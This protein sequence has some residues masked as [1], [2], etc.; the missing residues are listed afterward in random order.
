VPPEACDIVPVHHA[1]ALWDNRSLPAVHR[2]FAELLGTEALWVTMDR[3]GFKPPAS[4]S[5][6]YDRESAIHWDARPRERVADARPLLQGMLFLTD[7]S[8]ELGPFECVPSLYRDVRRWIAEH[9]DT[10]EP[11]VTGREIVRVVGDAG[12]LVVWNALLPHRAGRNDGT[13]PRITQYIAMR[14]AG[15][16]E[17][18]EERVALWR[19]RRIPPVWRSWPPTVIDPEPGARAELDALGRKLLGADP[20]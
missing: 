6:E 16:R 2:A 9:P 7:T 19:D 3:A 17:E 14:P 10:D 4:G 11:D 8:A 1:Q 18:A 20:W 12:D 13:T 15:G 5:R